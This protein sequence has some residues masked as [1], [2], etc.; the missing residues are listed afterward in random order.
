MT[1][2]DWI[3]LEE[4]EDY[5]ELATPYTDGMQNYIRFT[6]EERAVNGEWWQASQ[7]SHSVPNL[8]KALGSD[9]ISVDERLPEDG[10]WVLVWNGKNRMIDYFD[11]GQS[12]NFSF[13]LLV[14]QLGG[15]EPN[16]VTHWMPLPPPPEE[17]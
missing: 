14:H 13:G 12:D 5:R 2:N 1:Q 10:E 4:D 17:G 6:Q 16:D 11:Y 8:R 3:I 7:C 15:D 9:W